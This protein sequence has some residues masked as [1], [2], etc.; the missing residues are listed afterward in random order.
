MEFEELRDEAVGFM[1]SR[2]DGRKG[3]PRKVA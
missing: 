3:R 1:E 2:R